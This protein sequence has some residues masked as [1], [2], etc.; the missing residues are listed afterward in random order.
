MSL[1]PWTAIEIELERQRIAEQINDLRVDLRLL[2]DRRSEP[3]DRERSLA[4]GSAL[5]NLSATASS[6][7]IAK[8]T[9]EEA[10]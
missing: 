6:L 10:S 5:I 2:A 1:D 3:T 8:R 9:T 7:A 4:F